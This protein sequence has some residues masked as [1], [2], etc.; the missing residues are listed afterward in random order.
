MKANYRSDYKQTFKYLCFPFIVRVVRTIFTS[1][2]FLP[3]LVI[4][5][6]KQKEKAGPK[7]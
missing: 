3:D 1:L 4:Y 2:V 7:R 6:T 5:L